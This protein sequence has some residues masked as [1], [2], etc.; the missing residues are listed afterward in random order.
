[1]TMTRRLFVQAGLLVGA[2]A[3]L[4][5]AVHALARDAEGT[6]ENGRARPAAAPR[7]V[8][9]FHMDQPYVDYSGTAQP[10]LAPAGAR[11][12]DFIASLDEEA[13][14]ALRL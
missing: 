10:Y 3:L 1:M 9:S 7:P 2:L 8:V 11:S 6:R 4:P 13:I 5:K 12:A 14:A